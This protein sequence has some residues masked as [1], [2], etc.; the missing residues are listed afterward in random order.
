[1]YGTGVELL[2]PSCSPEEVP[3][4]RS[5]SGR[6]TGVSRKCTVTVLF[7]TGSSDALLYQITIRSGT[8]DADAAMRTC[9][10]TSSAPRKARLTPW[11]RALLAALNIVIDQYSSCPA[12]T[13]PW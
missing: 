8:P 3:R 13:K 12:E 6:L 9:Q 11:S 10:E 1:M 7:C 4:T 5:C 2:A